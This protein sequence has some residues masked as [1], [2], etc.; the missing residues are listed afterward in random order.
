[1]PRPP[2]IRY[3]CPNNGTRVRCPE[4]KCPFAHQRE[5]LVPDGRKPPSCETCRVPLVRA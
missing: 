2:A 3:V 1:M 5:E 4:C